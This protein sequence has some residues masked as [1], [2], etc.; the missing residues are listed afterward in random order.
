M[1]SG[2]VTAAA[3]LSSL[4]LYEG[5]LDLGT[6]RVKDNGSWTFLFKGAAGLHTEIHAV[7]TDSLGRQTSEPSNYSFTTGIVGKPYDFTQSNFDPDTG[8][9]TFQDFMEKGSDYL[10]DTVS[11]TSTG[12]VVHDYTQGSFF[13]AKTYS[14]FVDTVSAGGV[15]DT[16]VETDKDGSHLTEIDANQQTVRALGTDTFSNLADR[17]RFVFHPGV[18]T[19][20][21][22]GF[23]IGGA[24]HD[25]VSLPNADAS[26]L[27]GMLAHATGDGQGDTTL[28]IG[29][30]DTLTFVGLSVAQLQTHPG[31]FV[32]HA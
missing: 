31:D 7:A 21:I 25:I 2:R 17:T 30:G 16:H 11:R 29:Q 22:S 5:D 3:G 15:L 10:S 6:A 20:A 26:R 9:L 24:G 13:S 8:L 19:E 28:K 27:A 12:D 1:L 4:E 23:H 32:F 14:S 18:G